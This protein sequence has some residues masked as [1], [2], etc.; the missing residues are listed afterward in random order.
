MMD[1]LLPVVAI[2]AVIALAFSGLLLYEVW[3]M[4]RKDREEWK[5]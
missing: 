3:R 2:A 4:A 1:I 5:R